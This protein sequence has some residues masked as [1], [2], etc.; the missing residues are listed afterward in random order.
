MVIRC[1][2]LMSEGEGIECRGGSIMFLG[3]VWR[4]T[5]FEGYYEETGRWGGGSVRGERGGGC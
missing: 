5:S 4:L 3:K 2:G 1:C